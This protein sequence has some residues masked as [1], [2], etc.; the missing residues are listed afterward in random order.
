[1]TATKP[2]GIPKWI[3]NPQIKEVADQ[4][5]TAR[6]I[7]ENRH[8]K[9]DPLRLPL[10]NVGAMAV[11]LYLK[12][13]SGD[14]DLVPLEDLFPA[15]QDSDHHA[16]VLYAKAERGHDL[17]GLLDRVDS[18]IRSDLESLY[19]AWLEDDAGDGL[20]SDLAE[21]SS[22]LSASR[23]PYERQINIDYVNVAA[24]MNISEL[25]NAFTNSMT[26]IGGPRETLPATERQ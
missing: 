4:Y 1:M 17:P 19:D 5:E 18:D 3:P 26:P 16:F 7:L 2:T 20:R 9:E 8:S 15:G 21:L 6:Y 12:C 23:Y 25:L 13:L 10:I 14:L 11:E 22:A 24:L